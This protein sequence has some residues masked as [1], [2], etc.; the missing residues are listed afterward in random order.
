MDIGAIWDLIIL[1]P[2]IN[3]M[4]WLSHNLWGS[5]GLTVIVLTVVIR[6]ALW[7]LNR[8]QL[9][10]TKKMQEITV[11]MDALK[12]KHGNDRQKLA[13]EQMKLYKESGVSTTGCLVPML[14]QFPI[15]IALYQAIVRVLAVTPEDFM[16]LSNHL[17]SWPV[18]YETLP[19]SNN[20]LWMDLSRSDF[21][22]ALLV[23]L[24]MFVQQKMSTPKAINQQQAAQSQMLSFMMPFMFFF[25]SLSFP[26]GLAFYWFV[27]AVVGIIMQY[28]ITGW[29]Q[30][31]PIAEKVISYFRGGRQ[32]RSGSIYKTEKKA[33]TPAGQLSDSST[34]GKQMEG[35]IDEK[36]RDERQDS[37]G[38][39]KTGSKSTKR[40]PKRS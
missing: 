30:L 20:F 33:A 38:S 8:K 23:G 17:Y 28:F 32:V 2:M 37:G 24:G 5:F 36:G 14:I 13:E 19:L 27:S 40:K 22:L 9:T 6:L 21:V 11:H 18:V 39:Y 29:G 26:S 7:P 12:K 10:A 1:S 16:N 31:E 35:S 4:V 25:F 15:W 3:G 34:K